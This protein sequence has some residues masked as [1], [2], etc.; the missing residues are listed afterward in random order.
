MTII[1]SEWETIV[2]RAPI[3]S[4]DD[5]CVARDRGKTKLFLLSLLAETR[6]LGFQVP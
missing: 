6:E 2:F 3:S 5:S 1:S 4:L